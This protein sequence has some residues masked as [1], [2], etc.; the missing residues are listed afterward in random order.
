M[1]SWF[2]WDEMSSRLR[3]AEGTRTMLHRRDAMLRLGQLGLGAVTLPGLLAARAAAQQPAR[4]R[5]QACILLYL[6]GGPS[7]QDMWDMKP[8]T[9]QGIRSLFQPLRT[10]TPGFDL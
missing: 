6:W 10:A 3:L 7:Q 5:A 1:R 9:P 2:L 4:R 8:D